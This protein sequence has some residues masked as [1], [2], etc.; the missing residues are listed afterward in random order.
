MLDL[1]FTFPN[2]S[3]ELMRPG[4]GVRNP[5]EGV[6]HSLIQQTLYTMAPQK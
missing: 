5:R 2:I 4:I 3:Q 1:N 6:Y